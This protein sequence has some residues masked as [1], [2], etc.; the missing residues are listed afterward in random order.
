[1][2]NYKALIYSAFYFFYKK[3][4]KIINTNTYLISFFVFNHLFALI[5]INIRIFQYTLKNK[6]KDKNFT[7]QLFKIL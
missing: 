7:K 2:P 6:R 3:S 5:K 1:M 4:V